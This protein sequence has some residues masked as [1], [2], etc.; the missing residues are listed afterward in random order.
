MAFLSLSDLVQRCIVRLRQV[1]GVTTQAYAE[2]EIAYLIEECYEQC[3][4]LRWWDHLTSWNTRTLDGSTG[5][6]TVALTGAREGI[7]DVHA[8]F[9]GTQS[10]QLPFT[11]QNLNPARY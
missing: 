4:A 1:P 11:Q 9:A 10:A 7:R 5:K 3:R 2:T 8:V 6:F